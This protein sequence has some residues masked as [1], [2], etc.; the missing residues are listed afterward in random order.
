VAPKPLRRFDSSCARKV[1]FGRQ[2]VSAHYVP[3]LSTGRSSAPSQAFPTANARRE[4]RSFCPIGTS[5]SLPRKSLLTAIAVETSAD[6]FERC[7]S[8]PSKARSRRMFTWVQ[9]AAGDIG[10]KVVWRR[11]NEMAICND[12]LLS[13]ATK[14][15]FIPDSCLL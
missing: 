14:L 12:R 3:K 10:S 11:K 1:T 9:R 13:D 2:P 5:V 7:A 8:A 6:L 15:F 4:H